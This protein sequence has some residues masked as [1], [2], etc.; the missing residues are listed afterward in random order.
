M[1]NTE[2]TILFRLEE[3]LRHHERDLKKKGGERLPPLSWRNLFERKFYVD[4]LTSTALLVDE[5]PDE[6]HD[7]E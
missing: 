6:G 1:R 4:S 2:R 7:V 5:V 3:H